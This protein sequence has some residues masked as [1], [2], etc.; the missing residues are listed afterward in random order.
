MDASTSAL[1]A[2]GDDSAIL[3]P[4]DRDNCGIFRFC[5]LSRSEP[6]QKH[7]VAWPSSA[8][9]LYAALNPLR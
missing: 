4:R 6:K 9:S 2:K 5:S 3:S 8:R 1:V 7:W